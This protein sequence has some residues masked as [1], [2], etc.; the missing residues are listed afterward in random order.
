MNSLSSLTLRLRT[1]DNLMELLLAGKSEAW[2]IGKN[3]EQEI[4]KV[5]IFNWDGS[6]KLEATFDLSN[7]SRTEDNRLI[8]GLS[9][10]DSRIVR[11]DPPFE[12]VGQN[13]V[14]YFDK[15][16]QDEEEE[17]SS[18]EV[19]QNTATEFED[20]KPSKSHEESQSI[21]VPLEESKEKTQ[22]KELDEIITSFP[23]IIK[24]FLSTDYPDCI[25]DYVD[26]NQVYLSEEKILQSWEAIKANGQQREII[27]LAMEWAK[28][29]QNTFP[30]T[31]AYS[32]QYKRNDL[33]E[34]INLLVLTAIH[35]IA[36]GGG[37]FLIQPTGKPIARD[38]ED[39][40]LIS[41]YTYEI[42]RILSIE[43]TWQSAIENIVFRVGDQIVFQI[44]EPLQ[45]LINYKKLFTFSEVEFEIYQDNRVK[46]LMSGLTLTKENYTR[47]EVLM[48]LDYFLDKEVFEA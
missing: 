42:I 46:E 3:K 13:P 10:E 27:Q 2:K 8:V 20:K 25:Q 35:L 40:V 29:I 19:T 15:N 47:E 36:K 45:R 21:S 18:E 26:G 11:C 22:F 9:P 1:K 34:E 37:A 6:L 24:N 48:I 32:E 7:S 39:L 14:K 16:S 41:N 4:S 43:I 23:I 33:F 30:A 17:P 44:P 38:D 28:V 12:W 5:E 31:V